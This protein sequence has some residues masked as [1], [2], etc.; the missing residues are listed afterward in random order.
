MT[1]ATPGDSDTRQAQ[2]FAYWALLACTL[3]VGVVTFVL[4]FHGLDDYGRRVG[5]VGALSFLVPLGVDGL[6]LVAVAATFLLRHAPLRVRAYAWSVFLIANALSVGGNLSHA[7]AQN[8]SWDG[9][10]GAAAAPVLLT[11]ASHLVIVTKRALDRTPP[12]PVAA[13][14][15]RVTTPAATPARSDT[16]P[17]APADSKPRQPRP[18]TPKRDNDKKARAQALYQAGKSNAEIAL[19]LGIEKRTAE[20]HT[21]PLRQAGNGR[22]PASDKEEV[23]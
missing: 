23:S 12:R 18:A 8:L 15:P 10:V 4:S 11:L 3:L 9:A 5:K 19:A 13:A 22:P 16:R 20:R 1:H 21:K 7:H 2:R 14:A 17:P 6:T